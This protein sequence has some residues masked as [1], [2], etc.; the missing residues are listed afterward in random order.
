M[1][2]VLRKKN[3]DALKETSM[4]L[5]L[6]ASIYGET[7]IKYLDKNGIEKTLATTDDIPAVD[8]PTLQEV[9]TEGNS[10]TGT[11]LVGS[12]GNP[13]VVIQGDGIEGLNDSELST[14]TI[15]SGSGEA[16]FTSVTNSN[17]LIK[18][19]KSYVAQLEAPA[20]GN[21][22]VVV[23]LFE[24]NLSGNIT[25]ES[26]G[27]GQYEGTLTGAFTNNKTV[28]FI[29]MP[30]REISTEVVVSF[31]RTNTDLIYINVFEEDGNTSIDGFKATIEVRVYN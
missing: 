3:Q 12:T 29:N 18:P 30:P 22:P 27:M 8:T 23:N 6:F 11:I 16:A 15:E 20:D 9:I 14:W 26:V 13:F 24:N 5:E 21:D 19:Y 28:L 25:W 2:N 7:E 17:G 31:Q 4:G 10:T 1:F